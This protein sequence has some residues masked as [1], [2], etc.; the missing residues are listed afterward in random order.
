MRASFF[1]RVRDQFDL[2]V[3]LLIETGDAA[4]AFEAAEASRARSL[5]E[6]IRSGLPAGTAPETGKVLWPNCR[7]SSTATRLRW[8]TAWV[9]RPATY[10]W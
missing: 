6:L 2:K 4:A 1:A 10:S 8:N 5:Y 3:N 9:S 7:K